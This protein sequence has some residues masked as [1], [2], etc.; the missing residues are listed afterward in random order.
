M[1]DNVQNAYLASLLR[2]LEVAADSVCGKED[3]CVQCPKK[4]LGEKELRKLGDSSLRKETQYN[5]QAK[6]KG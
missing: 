1:F 5:G 4:N 6:Y 2:S 3:R